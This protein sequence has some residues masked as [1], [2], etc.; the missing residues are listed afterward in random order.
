MFFVDYRCSWGCNTS[1]EHIILSKQL[2]EHWLSYHHRGGSCGGDYYPDDRN[3]TDGC[4]LRL[5]TRT[6]IYFFSFYLRQG[7]YFTPWLV[8]WFVNKLHGRRVDMNNE[9]LWTLATVFVPRVL[10][11]YYSSFSFNLLFQTLWDYYYYYY[12]HHHH[13][14]H[15]CYYC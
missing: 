8:W 10:M 11:I 3:H 15:H 2:L 12:Y 4:Y 7:D 5:A 13:H 14:H 9:F 6:V 1:V